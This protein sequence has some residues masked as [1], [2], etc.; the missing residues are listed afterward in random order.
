MDVADVVDPLVGSILDDPASLADVD[1]AA[2]TASEDFF[3][4]PPL[5][6][7]SGL[8]ESFDN[9]GHGTVV[10]A[11]EGIA[12]DSAVAIADSDEL[13]DFLLDAVAWL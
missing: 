4:S 10:S 2:A 7:V 3:L 12:P 6:P 13:G 8:A 9:D 1:V 11:S 5:E